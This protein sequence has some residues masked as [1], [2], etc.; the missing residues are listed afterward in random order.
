[1]TRKAGCEEPGQKERSC[2]VCGHKAT[3]AIPATGHVWEEKYT[4]DVEPTYEKEGSESI[5]CSVCGQSEPVTE[6]AVPKK[7][8][9]F[10]V[11]ATFTVEKPA[12]NYTGNP[13]EPGVLVTYKGE[14]LEEGRDYSVAYSNNIDLGMA[15]VD[16]YGMGEY[17]GVKH[18]QF[19]I[20]IGATKKVTCTNVASGMKVSWEKVNGATRYKVY[21][22]GKLIFTTSALVVTDKDV[23]YNNG[24]KYVYKVVA[25]AKG[26]GD[27]D[28]FRTAT[29]YRLMPV[30]IK[31]LTNPA[32][33][34]MTVTYDKCSGST[35]YVVRYG[36][37]S[38][39]SD[40]RVITVAGANTLSRTFSGMK[41]GKLYYV[42]VR[43]YKLDN[44]V[45]YYS[46]YCTTKTITIKR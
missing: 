12:F 2:T 1:M 11:D 16:V 35:G 38:D 4:I 30:G 23:K 19:K 18:L 37:K 28:V 36:L 39:M 6:R 27:S 46:G 9:P 41:K 42:Q 5:H 31:S 15:N 44:G 22:D 13:I 14:Q 7:D 3:E 43:T 40:A 20:R 33:G 29:C 24:T 17:S 25:Y 21:R 10:S 45:R 8:D 34:Q 26:F 32:A